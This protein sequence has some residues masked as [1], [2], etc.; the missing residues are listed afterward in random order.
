MTQT[1]ADLPLKKN[2]NLKM[3]FIYANK[4]ETE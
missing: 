4:R 3:K 1:K 2:K